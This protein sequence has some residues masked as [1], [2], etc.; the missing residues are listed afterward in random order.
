[1]VLQKPAS[2]PILHLELPFK[3]KNRMAESIILFQ[4]IKIKMKKFVLSAC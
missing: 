1:M 2:S 3:A 4:E